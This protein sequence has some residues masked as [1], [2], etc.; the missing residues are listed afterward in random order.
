MKPEEGEVTEPVEISRVAGFNTMKYHSPVGMVQC[1]VLPVETMNRSS[2]GKVE[3]DR[4]TGEMKPLYR[5]TFLKDTTLLEHK[6]DNYRSAA[7]FNMEKAGMVSH[8]PGIRYGLEDFLTA[9]AQ[10]CDA[11]LLRPFLGGDL[12][13]IGALVCLANAA[14]KVPDKTFALV[15][16]YT[17]ALWD[18]S[19]GVVSGKYTLPDNLW[20]YHEKA[21]GEAEFADF[22]ELA[23]SEN[24]DRRGDIGWFPDKKDSAY[25]L[26]ISPKSGILVGKMFREHGLPEADTDDQD[27]GNMGDMDFWDT[28][29]F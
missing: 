17:K 18:F 13:C 2:G 3:M 12:C 6:S 11:T 25:T 8:V 16:A 20:I 23:Y 10:K 1:L 14:A 9:W 29:D 4:Y 15:S 5:T 24:A 26:G 27:T 21:V 19:S 28:D 7:T 22:P